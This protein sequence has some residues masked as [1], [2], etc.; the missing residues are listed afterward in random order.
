MCG[1]YMLCQVFL[2]ITDKCNLRCRYCYEKQR[3]NESMSIDIAKDIIS[4]F[5]LDQVYDMV[6]F[7]IF[8]GE[9]FIEFELIR[10]ICEWTWSNDW[11]TDYLFDFSTNG[12][13]FDDE[14][15]KWIAENSDRIKLTLSADGTEETQNFN[16]D[17]SY[18]MVD[19]NFF[20]NTWETP[21]VK[22]TI[23]N[24][25]INNLSKDVI[26]FHEKGFAFAACN[27]AEGILW[28]EED[29]RNF[30][31]ELEI[32]TRYYLNNP[33]IIVAPILDLDLWKCESKRE[34]RRCEIGRH[35][36]AY[37]CQGSAYPCNYCTEMTF[38]KEEIAEIFEKIKHEDNLSDSYCYEKCYYY[39]ICKS[40][41][42]ADYSLKKA[43]G[44]HN[45][46]KC[47]MISAQAYY[48]ALLNAE[49]IKQM[50]LDELSEDIKYKVSKTISTIKHILDF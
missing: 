30:R 29:E 16:R 2:T 26:F 18:Q 45:E 34:K 44:K 9:P 19:Y 17:N 35:F 43:F 41:C 7:V 39:P 42:A 32:L 49:K 24:E 6:D 50:N 40:C 25:T 22:M 10:E 4:K 21:Y 3:Q 20:V 27:L 23:D 36:Y 12:T 14:S 37:D 28:S 46:S 31:R 15:K 8:G 38:S 13:M 1:F 11:K 5:L 48:S 47:K 33:E